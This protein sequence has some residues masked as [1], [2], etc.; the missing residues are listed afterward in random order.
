MSMPPLS[1]LRFLAL[2]PPDHPQL[3]SNTTTTPEQT[4]PCDTSID[5]IQFSL[6]DIITASSI[7]YLDF[8]LLL[9][10]CL[11]FPTGSVLSSL[12]DSLK[13]L[14]VFLSLTFKGKTPLCVSG[15]K[16]IQWGRSE[17]LYAM[18]QY[19]TIQESAIWSFLMV[20]SNPSS[21]ALM[22]IDRRYFFYPFTCL[23]E[24]F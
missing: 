7:H 15:S 9:P 23:T 1:S 21:C 2:S 8:S 19:R 13:H 6:S 16:I 10:Q 14:N 22:D 5:I 4:N 24:A 20:V 18:Y 17:V 12:H 3:S 11:F